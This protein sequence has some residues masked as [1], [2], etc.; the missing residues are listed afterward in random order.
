MEKM[1]F[2]WASKDDKKKGSFIV[3]ASTTEEC[4]EIAEEE[5]GEDN[6]LIDYYSIN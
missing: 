6:D 4:V 5:I 1:E 3:T 2:V